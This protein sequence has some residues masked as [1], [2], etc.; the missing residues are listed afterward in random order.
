M[1]ARLGNQ[2]GEHSD[3]YASLPVGQSQAW[4]SPIA[5]G[6]RG[7]PDER[8]PPRPQATK[9]LGEGETHVGD[10][11]QNTKARDE[12]KRI[13][14]KIKLAIDSRLRVRNRDALEPGLGEVGSRFHNRNRATA[15][16]DG[17]RLG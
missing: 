13:I 8:V 12:V 17:K 9:K 5:H 1:K 15:T 16:D 2:V 10:V 6:D 3:G 14:R 4:S 7:L 11:V